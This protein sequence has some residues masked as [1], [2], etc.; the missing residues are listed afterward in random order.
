MLVVGLAAW[1][2]ASACSGRSLN[3]TAN[4][5]SGD[6][7]CAT[8]EVCDLSEGPPRRPAIL[9]PCPNADCSMGQACPA[10]F[11]C[12]ATPNPNPRV[13]CGSLS[14][15]QSCLAT[16]C[17]MDEVCGASQICE[18]VSC[19]A[20]DAPPCPTHWRCDPEATVDQS[21]SIAGSELPDAPDPARA[22]GHG[23]V[24][25]RCDE[26][27]GYVCASRFE[28]AFERAL[29]S[30]GCA[31][32]PCSE[33][34]SCAD[35]AR[36]ICAATSSV[37][38]PALP[39]AFGCVPRHCTQGYE[40]R[41]DVFLGWREESANVLTCEPSAPD[42]NSYGCASQTCK[43]VPE[44]CEPE[45]AVCDPSDPGANLFGCRTTETSGGSGG[46][47]P[48]VPLGQCVR[49]SSPDP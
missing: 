5:C 19:D 1:L 32:K 34:G 38:P 3:P 27:D 30:S 45:R 22:I 6:A 28:C 25:L 15:V 39:D 18:L 29:D 37:P 46:T 23:C 48:D 9:L 42:A 40:C 8:G 47:L 26:P 14:C 33:S 7:D 24:R 43:D 36:F 31:P 41:L 2:A 12:A 49:A 11:V 21:P 16:G 44:W 20:I 13:A 4:A 10:D 35:E 17:A